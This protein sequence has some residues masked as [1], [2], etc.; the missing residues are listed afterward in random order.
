MSG[1][2][3]Y[4]CVGPCVGEVRKDVL[5]HINIV[6]V[7]VD[8]YKKE[9]DKIIQD[10]IMEVIPDNRNDFGSWRGYSTFGVKTEIAKIVIGKVRMRYS[11]LILKRE[12]TPYVMHYLYKPGG[13][14]FIEIANSTMVGR[15]LE[16]PEEE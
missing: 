1:G 10:V 15:N 7:G 9:K 6:Q 13:R 8:L 12:F 2:P 3:W 4:E 14:R 11:I 5:N 16:N